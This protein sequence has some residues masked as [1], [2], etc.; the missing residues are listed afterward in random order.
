MPPS[1]TRGRAHRGDLAVRCRAHRRPLRRERGFQVPEAPFPDAAVAG[2]SAAHRSEGR[3]RDAGARGSAASPG[4]GGQK[5]RFD[6]AASPWYSWIR[7][8]GIGN[9]DSIMRRGRGT[10]VRDLI[11]RLGRENPRWGYQR[12]RGELLKLGIRVSATTVRT[13]LLRHGLDPAPCRGGPTWTEFLR[14]QA[15][16][17]LATDFFT[18]ET[19]TLKTI[20]VLLLHR[21]LDPARARGRRHRQPRLGV[22][23]PASQEPRHRGAAFG[24]SVPP[25]RPGRQVLGAIRCGAPR[26]GRPRHPNADPRTSGEC[27]CGAVREDRAPRVPRP[28][29]DLEPTAPRASPPSALITSRTDPIGD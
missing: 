20:Y 19:I 6:H 2:C 27:I 26:R 18:V 3:D 23:H 1:C 11:V 14:S 22:G 8:V 5:P 10:R 12:I 16:G 21:A 28:C 4:R 9:P 25:S 29:P 24:C 15:A 17:I 13:I 7:P